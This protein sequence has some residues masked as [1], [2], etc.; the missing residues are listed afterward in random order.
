V[1]GSDRRAWRT[2][3]AT[4]SP[5]ASIIKGARRLQLFSHGHGARWNAATC[6]PLF[7]RRRTRRKRGFSSGP[8]RAAGGGAIPWTGGS[9]ARTR[10]ICKTRPYRQVWFPGDHAS[11]GGGGDVNGLWQAALVWV[12][13]GAQLRGL[14]LMKRHSRDIAPISTTELRSTA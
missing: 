2:V 5:T 11:V 10:A 8:F 3:N 9:I 7:K 13:E 12:V 14:A 6:R 1:A 4:R